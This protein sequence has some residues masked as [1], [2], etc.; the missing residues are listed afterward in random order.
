MFDNFVKKC[1][2]IRSAMQRG[3]IMR[4]FGRWLKDPKFGPVQGLS[5]SVGRWLSDHFTANQVTLI[6]L[7]I[8]IPMSLF[9]M[10]DQYIVGATL[11][12]ISLITDFMD[13]ALS[14][15][16]QGSRPAM[17]LDE[18]VSLTLW[19]RVNYR[20]V[21]HLGRTLD[22]LADKLRFFLVLY[23]LGI[24]YVANC[25]IVLLTVVAVCLTLMRPIKQYLK[26]DNVSSNRFGKIK[27]WAEIIGMAFLVF[28]PEGYH[29]P[30]IVTIVNTVFIFALAFGVFSLL[31]HIFTGY[32]SYRRRSWQRIKT[33]IPVTVEST[34][35]DDD[36]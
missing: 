1:K 2:I 14:R 23:S 16:Q 10:L 25:V 7:V 22:P 3:M 20:G 17:T 11:L 19:K 35:T 32:L 15:Y 24:G 12:T 26:L 21:T 13:G 33:A 28:V 34:D 31:G 8:C 30:T 4:R 27:I 29:H 18:E 5:K 6:G 9:F 36:F